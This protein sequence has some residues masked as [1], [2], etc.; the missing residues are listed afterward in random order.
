MRT[1][2]VFFLAMFVLW[3][4]NLS[5]DQPAWKPPEGKKLI[6]YGW[7]VPNTAYVRRH[8]RKMER[9]PT[10]AQAHGKLHYFNG[11]VI[12]GHQEPGAVPGRHQGRAG[13]ENLQYGSFSSRRTTH[14]Q[15]RI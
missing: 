7:D 4:G 11:L 5:A 15:S 3:A 12:Q 14:T 2:A 10:F 9:R 8:I 6:Q 13:M 1:T